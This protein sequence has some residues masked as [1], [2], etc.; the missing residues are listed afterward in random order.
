MTCDAT[1]SSCADPKAWRTAQ[2]RAALAG[3]QA[4]LL[5]GRPLLVVTR[6]NLTR[7]FNDHAAFET[8]LA[9]VTGVAA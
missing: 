1:C 4:V 8:W 6:W 5:D 7:S 9:R 2:A 3:Y